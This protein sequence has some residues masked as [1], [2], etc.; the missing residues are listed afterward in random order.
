MDFEAV[1][2]RQI[3][4]MWVGSVWILAAFM[5]FF[6][7]P[8]QWSPANLVATGLLGLAGFAAYRGQQRAVDA[9]SVLWRHLFLSVPAVLVV[10]GAALAVWLSGRAG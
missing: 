6:M 4:V 2:A 9:G 3:R 1:A 10:A 8:W 7:L 5:P